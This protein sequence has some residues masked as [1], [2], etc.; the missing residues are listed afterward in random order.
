MVFIIS[1]NNVYNLPNNFNTQIDLLKEGDKMKF[2]NKY[3]ITYV[4][5]GKRT[6]LLTKSGYLKKFKG[7]ENAKK[8]LK[9]FKGKGPKI[10][11]LYTKRV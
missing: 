9:S 8:F 5:K 10:R 6:E 11:K 2:E 7:K 1:K 3:I 4:K